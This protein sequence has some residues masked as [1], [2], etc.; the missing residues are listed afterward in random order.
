MAGLL[1]LTNYLMNNQV[2]VLKAHRGNNIKQT[3]KALADLTLEY[4]FGIMPLTRSLGEAYVALSNRDIMGHYAP[5]NASGKFTSVTAD[6][7]GNVIHDGGT[8]ANYHARRTQEFRVRFKGMFKYEAQLDRHKVNQSLGLTWRELVPTLH[9]LI[10]YSFLVDYATNLGDIMGQIAVPW[11]GVAW[12]NATDRTWDS[13]YTYFG[14]QR[15]TP[16]T[17][18]ISG[19]EWT[20]SVPF[21][22]GYTNMRTWR[23]RRRDQ[24]ATMPTLRFEVKRP[25]TKQLTNVIALLTSRLPVLGN[26]TKKVLRSPSGKSLDYEFRLMRRDRNLKVPYPR[27]TNAP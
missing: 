13:E 27:F 15:L 26:L 17:P 6:Y 21:V 24:T 2:K 3:A 10:P 18:G 19:G 4:R 22:P 11:G 12:C 20:A 25:S 7:S 1:N 23:V 14:S 5:F 16:P 8:G 9:N